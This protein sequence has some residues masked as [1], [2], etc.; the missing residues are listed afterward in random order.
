MQKRKRP[1]GLSAAKRETIHE[2]HSAR[3]GFVQLGTCKSRERPILFSWPG[4]RANCSWVENPMVYV[5]TFAVASASG[6]DASTMKDF[7]E[8]RP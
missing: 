8:V 3:R 6:R 5:I 4:K 7:A 1:H 2:Q